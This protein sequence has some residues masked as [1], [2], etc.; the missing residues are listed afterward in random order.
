[1]RSSINDAIQMDVKLSFYVLRQWFEF[2]L[3]SIIRA[4]CVRAACQPG[5]YTRPLLTS[6]WAIGDTQHIP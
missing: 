1:M 2:V 5:S 3:E 6:I 4:K